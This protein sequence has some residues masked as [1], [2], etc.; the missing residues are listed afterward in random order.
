LSTT[1]ITF[2]LVTTPADE[3]QPGT[4]TD[5][6]TATRVVGA[7]VAELRGK[8]GWSAAD[9]A[10]RLADEGAPELNRWVIA[11]LETGRRESVSIDEVLVLAYVLDVSPLFLFVDVTNTTA[12]IVGNQILLSDRLRQW[13]RGNVPLGGQDPVVYERERPEV[14]WE[15]RRK[16]EDLVGDLKLLAH[17]LEEAVDREGPG[18]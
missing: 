9:L 10:R 1:P 8:R 2:V 12:M 3:K 6:L 7:R 5:P 13:V 15:P 14:E 11:N 18:R 17:L 16:V 4:A